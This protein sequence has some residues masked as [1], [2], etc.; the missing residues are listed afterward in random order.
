MLGVVVIVGCCLLAA[1]AG[2]ATF[3][4]HGERKV[5][6][7]ALLVTGLLAVL[8]AAVVIGSLLD[9]V[10]DEGGLARS[11][12]AV[13]EWGARHSDGVLAEVMRAVTWLGARPVVVAALALAAA[14]EVHRHGNREVIAFVA[15]VGI[16]EMLLMNAL[17]L[18]VDRD[19]PDVLQL[20]TTSG[21]SFPS[22]H[23]SAAAAA[24]MAVALVMGRGRSAVQRGGLALAAIAIAL[25]VAA[26]RAV[27]GV[28]WFTDVLA[29]LALGWGWYLVVATVFG[30][31]R[32]RLGAPL[33]TAGAPS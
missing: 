24:W 18:L 10:D 29:G 26:S 28:H 12:S 19:R 27:L 32:Q 33:V 5:A 20:V 30:G 13:A 15:A 22:G 8:A 14:Y 3:A 21:S 7:S 2:R 17:K 16:G 11:D 1:A 4:A 6:G 9:M 25:A 31:R 23:T